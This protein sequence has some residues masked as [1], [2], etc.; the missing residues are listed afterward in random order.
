[1]QRQFLFLLP[2]ADDA[3]M[4]LTGWLLVFLIHPNG[5]SGKSMIDADEFEY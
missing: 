3:A 1:M 5:R 4:E 2:H